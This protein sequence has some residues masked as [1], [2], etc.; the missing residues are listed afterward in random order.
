MNCMTPQRWCSSSA[1][2]ISWS[3][4]VLATTTRSIG[5]WRTNKNSSTL[6]RLY[7]EAQGKGAVWSSPPKITPP[8]IVTDIAGITPLIKLIDMLQ[9]FPI[10]Y[11]LFFLVVNLMK[12][13][14]CN[15]LLLNMC[16]CCS[17]SWNFMWLI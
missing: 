14:G 8:S 4:L 5:P 2:S 1:T 13:C 17:S 6:L 9:C 15:V 7:I 16:F 12:F 3:I 10:K 11:V